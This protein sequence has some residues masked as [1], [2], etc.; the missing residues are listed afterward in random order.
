MEILANQLLQEPSEQLLDMY[1]DR[2]TPDRDDKE[3][4]TRELIA[5]ALARR[6]DKAAKD[7]TKDVRRK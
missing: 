5:G 3:V 7:F 4:R 2:G 6:Q 1:Y